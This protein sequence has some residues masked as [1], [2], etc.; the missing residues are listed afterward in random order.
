MMNSIVKY[1]KNMKKNSQLKSMLQEST[2]FD[3]KYVN[4]DQNYKNLDIVEDE[5]LIEFNNQYIK[6]FI[7][8]NKKECDFD[9]KEHLS[10]A[11]K[12]RNLEMVS[13]FL[14]NCGVDILSY[15]FDKTHP[16]CR[17]AKINDVDIVKRLMEE[18]IDL[19]WFCIDVSPVYCAASKGSF[20]VLKLLIEEYD[21]PFSASGRYNVNYPLDIAA[22]YGHNDVFEYLLYKGAN[23]NMRND[24]GMLL[25]ESI[26]TEEG[27]RIYEEFLETQDQ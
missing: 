12:N 5:E 2:D 15:K 14:E 13:Y 11:V 1:F 17:A 20:E 21:A 3:Y 8:D 10:T 24:D 19:D 25:D 4:D 23:Y 26:Y 18:D 27:M 16:L 6:K 9:F 7:E 22:C